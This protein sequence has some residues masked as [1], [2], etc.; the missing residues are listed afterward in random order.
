S[1]DV[2]D[3][4]REISGHDFTAKD[5]RKWAATVRAAR[6]LAGHGPAESEARARSNVV[7]AI[8]EAAEWLG[9]TQAVARKAYVDPSVID[10]YLEGDTLVDRPSEAAVLS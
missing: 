6:E 5:F 2:N 9:N 10:A 1:S 4:V 8:E 7:R 3:Y